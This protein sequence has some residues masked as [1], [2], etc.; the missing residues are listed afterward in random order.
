M[1]RRQSWRK[2]SL[3]PVVT[4]FK[5]AG[6]RLAELEEVKL[7]VEEAEAIRLRDLDGLDQEDCAGKMNVSRSTFSR[8]LDS[9]RQKIADALLN[10]KAIRIE[11][12]NFE[13]AM[14]RFRCLEGHEWEVPF[15]TMI[16]TPPEFCPRCETPSIMP[17]LPPGM[18]WRRGGWGGR[19]RGGR[20]W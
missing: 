8:I 1:G 15:E 13:L 10:G 20:R 7:L 3:I 17:L 9:A 16:S 11:G 6:I 19:Y 5:P 18:S 12:G 4:Y 2:V 14:R